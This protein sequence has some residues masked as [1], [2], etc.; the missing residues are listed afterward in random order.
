[1][2]E[3]KQWKY[4]NV[5]DLRFHLIRKY[6]FCH[7]ITLLTVKVLLQNLRQ[8]EPPGTSIGTILCQFGPELYLQNVCFKIFSNA[9]LINPAGPTLARL[10]DRIVNP[11]LRD[12]SLLGP[13]FKS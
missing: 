9:K 1:M 13:I 12:H 8:N 11:A 3:T 10:E 2:G 5:V 7:K 4:F 6:S